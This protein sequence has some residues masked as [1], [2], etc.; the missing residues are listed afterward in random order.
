[1]SSSIFIADA[2]IRLLLPQYDWQLPV[3]AVSIRTDH[4]LP[5]N[6]PDTVDLFHPEQAVKAAKLEKLDTAI[7]EIRRRFGKNAI[8]PACLL[9]DLKMPGDGR[10]QIRLPGRMYP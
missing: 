8:Q 3:R 7:D 4:L 10:D 2:I 5:D 1:M 9:N 6:V